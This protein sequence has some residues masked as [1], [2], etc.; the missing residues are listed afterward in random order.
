[1]LSTHWH[2]PHRTEQGDLHLLDLL[3]QQAVDIIE[4]ARAEEA[5]RTNNEELERLN[6]A[7][8]GRELRMVELKKEV[9]E[10]CVKAGLQPPYKLDFE[11]EQP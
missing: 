1:M 6:R 11:K 5:L 8:V 10:L 9:N 3:A 7:M 2:A 4:F